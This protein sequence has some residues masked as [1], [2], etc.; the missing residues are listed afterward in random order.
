MSP[1]KVL[2]KSW[3][4]ICGQPVFGVEIWGRFMY[5]DKVKMNL[6]LHLVGTAPQMQK[7]DMTAAQNNFTLGPWCYLWPW[8]RSTS[9]HCTSF[10]HESPFLLARL[11]SLPSNQQLACQALV[12]QGN[13]GYSID[14]D[15]KSLWCLPTW[16]RE[17]IQAWT[18]SV[19][20]FAPLCPKT[21]LHCSLNPSSPDCP[22]SKVRFFHV[23]RCGAESFSL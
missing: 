22:S 12:S 5:V 15:K 9:D 2:T 1:F 8:I 16:S 23:A 3:I 11:P 6:K 21:P 20:E 4:R 17:Q 18:D 14:K 19:C 10:H 13:L 7:V